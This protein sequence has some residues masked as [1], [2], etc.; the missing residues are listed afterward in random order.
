MGLVNGLSFAAH[1][2][3][4]LPIETRVGLEML[5]GAVLG[6]REPLAMV[7]G[8]D[9]RRLQASERQLSRQTSRLREQAVLPFS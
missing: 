3:A 2:T 8:T 6:S 7:V 5:A 1:A 9:E 4:D